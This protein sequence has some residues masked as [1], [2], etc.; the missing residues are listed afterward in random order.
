MYILIRNAGM[1][2]A[3]LSRPGLLRQFVPNPDQGKE[4]CHNEALDDV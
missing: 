1:L 4:I 2:F 3:Q